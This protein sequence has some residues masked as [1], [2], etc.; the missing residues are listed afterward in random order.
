MTRDGMRARLRKV[1][2]EFNSLGELRDWMGYSIGFVGRAAGIQEARLRGLEAGEPAALY[3]L[4]RLATLY[5][6]DA[7]ALE[8]LPVRL[9]PGDGIA[10]LTSLDEFRNVSD[11][12]RALIVAAA[13]AARDLG[14]LARDGAWETFAAQV[15]RLSTRVRTL[16]PHRAGA[17]LAQQLRRDLGLG[18]APIESMRDFLGEFFSEIAVLYSD[19]SAHG[20]AG[21]AFGD[22]VRGPTIVLNTTGKN[23][24]PCVRRFSLAH[25]LCHLL[26]DWNR[27]QPIATISGYLN[28]TALDLERRANAFAVRLLCPEAVL[29]RIGRSAAPSEVAAALRPYGLPYSAVRLYLRNEAPVLPA[30]RGLTALGTEAKWARSEEPAGIDS[31]P[32]PE[33]TTERRTLI[34]RAA[35][36]A[37]SNDEISRDA[38]AE[39][40]GVTPAS[41]LERVL[42]YFVLPS[43]ADERSAV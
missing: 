14:K 32:L 42:D 20:P 28:D 27:Q 29:R 25:E 34:A 22:R 7:D 18:L 24:N 41:D 40:L 19:L 43:P 39:Y 6:V 4:E 12:V 1:K 13:N 23:L 30:S 26:H 21:L 3:E 10:C 8:D 37:Y 15:P 16:P 11:S 31:F 38:F 5:G 36:A 9:A 17:A 35:A 2:S 33:V